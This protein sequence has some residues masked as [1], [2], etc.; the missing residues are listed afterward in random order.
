METL[1]PFE[2]LQILDSIISDL[3]YAKKYSKNKAKSEKQLK[4]L[5]SVRK[6]LNV[7]LHQS[8]GTD[9]LELLIFAYIEKCMIIDGVQKGKT[10]K[11]DWYLKE[12]GNVMGEGAAFAK[13]KVMSQIRSGYDKL[14]MDDYDVNKDTER[15]DKMMHKMPSEADMS[16]MLTEFCK[17]IITNIKLKKYENNNLE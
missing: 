6:N 1:K 15:V 16:Q 7:M 2:M 8:M 12:L 3:T 10:Y 17:L 14:M 4:Q 9:S 13:A 11:M 5:V